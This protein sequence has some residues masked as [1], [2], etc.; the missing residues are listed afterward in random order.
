MK[1]KMPKNVNDFVLKDRE[2]PGEDIKRIMNELI[3]KALFYLD[4][5]INENFDESVHEIRKCIKR[6][7]AALRLIRDAAGRR[8][9][10]RENY[11]FRDINRNLSEIR[12]IAVMIETLNKLG[13]EGLDEDYGK[14]QHYFSALKDKIVYRLC[15]QE[16]RLMNVREMLHRGKESLG[17]IAAGNSIDILLAGFVRVYRQCLKCMMAAMEEPGAAG[18]HEWR[19]KVKYMYYQMQILKPLLPDDFL[20]YESQLDKLSEYLGSD[21]DLEELECSLSGNK[22][23]PGNIRK[24]MSAKRKITESRKEMQKALFELSDQIFDEKLES[25]IKN[26]PEACRSVTVVKFGNFI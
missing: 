1:M 25:A 21:H 26:I 22:P 15:E 13:G 7:R 14:L 10:R 19:K 17:R 16:N 24:T 5:G 20:V 8:H 9:Y 6:I 4:E 23:A 12:T 11:Y 2:S 3:D 18:L